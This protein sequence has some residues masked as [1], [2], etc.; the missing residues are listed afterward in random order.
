MHRTCTL[1]ALA[2][3]LVACGETTPPPG[4]EPLG[5]PDADRS[6][7]TDP[8]TSRP[9]GSQREPNSD[10]ADADAGGAE[11]S[12]EVEPSSDLADTAE[13]GGVD[14]LV[15][16]S[17]DADASVDIELSET[18]PE[19][20]FDGVSDSEPE[21]DAGP[22]PDPVTLCAGSAAPSAATDLGI[23]AAGEALA[24]LTVTEDAG[25]ERMG[26]VAFSAVPLPQSAAVVDL[27]QLALVAGGHAVPAQFE[28][29]SRWGGLAD[30]EGLP[31]QWLQVT[32]ATE[33]AADEAAIYELRRVAAPADGA[34]LTVTQGPTLMIDTGPA[35]FEIDPTN[36]ALLANAW[37]GDTPVY[38]DGP[39]AGPS[40]TVD[41][42]G[43]P[44]VFD[45]S[46]PGRV[47]LDAEGFEL[48]QSGPVRATVV[49][50]GHFVDPEGGTICETAFGDYERYG[51]TVA[52]SFTRGSSAIDVEYHVRNECGDSWGGP[53]TDDTALFHDASWRLAVASGA[54]EAWLGGDGA[55]AQVASPGFAQVEQRRGAFS[56]PGGAWARRARLQIGGATLSE[57][58]TL[59]APWLAVGTAGRVWTAAM[60]WM[61]YR[62]PQ[63]LRWQ[64]GMLALAIVSEA[65]LVGEAKGIWAQGRFR[66]LEGGGDLEA[67]RAADTAG[68]ERGL[69][70]M[71]SRDAV[72][73][74]GVF[75]SLGTDA[76][77]ALKTN[78]LGV[79]EALHEDTIEPS[80]GQWARAKTYGSQLWPDTQYDSWAIDNATPVDCD[81]AMNYWNPLGA[82]LY[83]LFRSGDP[84][85]AWE[86]ALPA[87]WLQM[88][89]AYYNIGERSWGARNG[90]AVT[91]G[92]S[93]DGQ[94]HR[95]AWGSGDYA[96]NQGQQLAYVVRPS[97]IH[98]DRFRQAGLTMVERYDIPKSME[99][100]R[101]LYFNQVVPSRGV[102]QHFEMIANCAQFVPG[103]AGATCRER[104][105]DLVAEL[106]EDNLSHGVMCSSDIPSE[107]SCWTPQTFMQASMHFAFFVRIQRAIGDPTGGEL[108]SALAEIA[109]NY[110]VWGLDTAPDGAIAT[111]LGSTWAAGLECDLAP[112]GVSACAVSPDG[113]GNT[114]VYLPTRPQ[115]LALMLIGHDLDPSVGGAGLCDV[116]RAAYDAPAIHQAAVWTWFHE[117]AG[118]WKGSNQALQSLVF[119]VGLYDTCAD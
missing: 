18:V 101:D 50:R 47:E 53:W 25:V 9:D 2:L 60:P 7:L 41:V 32:V 113:E 46:L 94:W 114:S 95:S 68:L 76:D 42:A 102:L 44:M 67:Y 1:F 80:E 26:E 97:P 11:D 63:A 28:A 22:E 30:D 15:G 57:P 40:L 83:E 69:L 58:A 79:L 73:A 82:E 118:Y 33:V 5:A 49:G 55:L 52:L 17:P 38:E 116:Y 75:P 99:A 85:W 4:G 104:L 48:V 14:D 103:D 84:R 108:A 115:M 74:S 91:S 36:P 100:E 24:C 59:D 3:L 34:A 112:G 16:R 77:S 37:L 31:V 87:A 20:Q 70:V 66:V 13:A 65:Q 81:G 88:Y 86:M 92:G 23:A 117:G 96:Y 6:E 10:V 61:R 29:L 35:R 19:T 78:Y 8:W 93:G 62:E 110:Y 21:P 109:H 51:Y 106:V 98:R 45:T 12:L 43:A 71:A 56:G 54:D 119:G 90:V 27:S 72:N 64:D 105:D 107:S 39:G 111:G 89:T